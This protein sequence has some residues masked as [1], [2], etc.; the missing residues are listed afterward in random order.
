MP[1]PNHP[2]IAALLLLL[3][4]ALAACHTPQPTTPAQKTTPTPTPTPTPDWITLTPGLR[5]NRQSR[6]VHFDAAIATDCHNP[7][8]PDVYLELIACTPDTREHESLVVTTVPPSLIHAA[9]LAINATPGAPGNLANN[10]PPT[11]Q[12]I[13]VA[14]LNP[15][16]SETPITS[17]ITDAPTRTKAPQINFR[18]AG[19]KIIK[20][21]T[22]E[23]FAADKAGTVIGLTTFGSELIACD[24]LISPDAATDTPVWIANNPKIPSR[25]HPVTIQLKPK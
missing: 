23:T 2:P 13:D 24:A 4:T 21:T 14:I 16:G 6:A 7:K 22:G 25:G 15:D 9:L 8:T 18:F 5:L 20:T 10:T 3:T 11:G 19:S 1:T 12:L 17:W